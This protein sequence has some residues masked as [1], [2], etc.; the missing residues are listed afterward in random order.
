M[1]AVVGKAVIRQAFIRQMAA[2]IRSHLA[3][4]PDSTSLESL[5]I[6]AERA[7]ASEN[8]AKDSGL[9]VCR[10]S[11]EQQRE[12]NRNHGIHF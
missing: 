9:G 6:L 12:I 3:M 5:V 2:S 10:D 8:D 11:I 7:L 4:T 1:S